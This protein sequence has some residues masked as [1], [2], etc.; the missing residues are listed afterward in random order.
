MTQAAAIR[1]WIEFPLWPD[2]SNP[3]EYWCQY[4]HTFPEMEACH[5]VHLQTAFLMAK[6]TELQGSHAILLKWHLPVSNAEL[7]H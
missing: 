3:S 4:S 2:A 7:T 5:D 1:F 6:Y